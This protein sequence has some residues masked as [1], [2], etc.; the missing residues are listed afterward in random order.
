MECHNSCI[1]MAAPLM[2]HGV[3]E[4][5]LEKETKWKYGDSLHSDC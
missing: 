3:Q 2:T 5:M 4:Y 1:T